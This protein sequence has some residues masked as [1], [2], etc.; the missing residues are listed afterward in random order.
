[1]DCDYE[2]AGTAAVFM[3][4][5]P[6]VG[7]REAT[8]RPRRTNWLNIADLELSA[9]TRQCLRGRRIGD[10][11]T[12]RTEVAAWS[13]DTHQPSGSLAPRPPQRGHRPSLMG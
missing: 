12:L 2:S 3:F 8:V 10:L 4:S 11:E 13:R 9:M 5:E 6:V 1:M 7:L